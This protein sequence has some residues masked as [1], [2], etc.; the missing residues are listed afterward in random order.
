M[1]G[2]IMLERAIFKNKIKIKIYGPNIELEDADCNFTTEFTDEIEP[3]SCKLTIYNLSDKNMNNIL[4]N[5]Q[6]VEIFTNQYNLKDDDGSVLWQLAFS[7]IL[8]EAVKK[9][10]PTKSGKPSKAK[11]KI[12]KPAITTESDDADDYIQIELQE[13]DGTDIGT[14]VSK[15]YKK[16]FN[17]KKILTSLAEMIDMEIVFDKN[18]QN[19]NLTYP[20]ILHDNVRKSLGK[21]ASYLNATCTISNNRIYI[22]SKEPNGK[23]L[24]YHFDETNIQRPRMIQGN[25]IEFTAPY[26]A[27]LA[28][29]SFIRLSNKKIDIDGIYQICK[30]E[31][32]FSNHSEDCETKVTV[33]Y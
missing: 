10:K 4:H 1:A 12:L 8:R 27:P 13:G 11:P 25:K 6:Y 3:N 28:V 31:S 33:K 21:I 23:A 24:Y 18:I 17:T 14:F 26:I 22:M 9:P 30:L 19:F 32:S 29:G 7:G 15:S 20:I 2:S 16:G 5:T